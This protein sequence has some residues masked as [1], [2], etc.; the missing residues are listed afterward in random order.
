MRKIV[1]FI[2]MSLDGFAAGPKGEMDWIHVDAEIFDFVGD[3]TNGADTALYGRVTYDM[4][5]A[6]WPHAAE[7]PNA[8]KHEIEHGT[9]YNKV[10]KLV[11]SKSMEGQKKDKTTIIGHDIDKQVSEIKNKPGKEIIIFGSPRATQTLMEYQLVDELWVFVNPVLLGTGMPFF[12]NI[13][14]PVNLKLVKSTPFAEAGVV[15]LH[16]ETIK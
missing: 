9:W 13:K 3:R 10:E 11:I 12:K 14:T 7:K 8:T 1:S 5:D 4:M 6:Y 16:Y 15:C 2:H